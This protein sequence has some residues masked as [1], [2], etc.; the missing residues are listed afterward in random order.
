M[1]IYKYADSDGF[2]HYTGD[3]G[4]NLIKDKEEYVTTDRIK[5]S[6]PLDATDRK[7]F[8]TLESGQGL[9]VLSDNLM[10]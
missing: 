10:S 6:Q 2:I 7:L 9:E 4:Q 3:Y 5:A 8:S 1:Y